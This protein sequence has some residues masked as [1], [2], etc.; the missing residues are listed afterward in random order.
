[1]SEPVVC[2]HAVMTP[3]N[4]AYETERLIAE[5]LYHRRPVYMAFPADLANQ[6]V[7]GD[8]QPIAAPRSNPK[9]LAAAADAVVAALDRAGTAC[10]IAGVLVGRTGQRAVLQKLID[11]SGLPFGTMLMGKSVHQALEAAGRCQTGAYIEVVTDGYAAS[12]LAM[13]LHDAVA[14]LYKS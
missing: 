2:G 1:M 8:A 12:P 6:P 9:K 11:A 13:K 14:T 5:A 10:V 7:L 4:V 3:Q